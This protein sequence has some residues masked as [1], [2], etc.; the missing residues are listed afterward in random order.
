MLPSKPLTGY[1][2][3]VTRNGEDVKKPLNPFGSINI[4]ADTGKASALPAQAS[5]ERTPQN[6]SSF[7]STNKSSQ[8]QKLNKSFLNWLNLQCDKNPTC[9]WREGVQVICNYFQLAIFNGF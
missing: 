2:S 3:S 7:K 8:I 9:I 1:P 6:E 5:V 4:L